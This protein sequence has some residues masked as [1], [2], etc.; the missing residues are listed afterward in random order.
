ME[1]TEAEVVKLFANTH[2]AL[3][4]SYF[5]ELDTYAKTKSLNT[6]ELIDS[7]CLDSYIGAYY[8]N[9]SFSYRSYGGYCMQKDT[10]QLLANF[11][12]VRK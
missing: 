11:Q 4:V 1:F 9:P 8:I 3:H 7:V 12:D 6:Q 2:L 5:N 10:K